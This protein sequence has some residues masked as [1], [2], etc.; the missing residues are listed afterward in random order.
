MSK[1]FELARAAQAKTNMSID[2]FFDKFIDDIR[3][4][5]KLRRIAFLAFLN[6]TYDSREFLRKII[7]V[8][9]EHGSCMALGNDIRPAPSLAEAC[10]KYADSL[11][12]TAE[13]LTVDE[14]RIAF[15]NAV[16]ESYD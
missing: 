2:E 9:T 1:L 6:T 11:G 7:D 14:R 10:Q 16:I 4:Y 5:R 15:L 13:S 12:R 8:T 3:L